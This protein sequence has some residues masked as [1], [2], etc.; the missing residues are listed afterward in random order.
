MYTLNG[1]W[2]SGRQALSSSNCLTELKTKPCLPALVS[3]NFYS[4][5]LLWKKKTG[6]A[7]VFFNFLDR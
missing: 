4:S 3:E 7:M 1:Y 5:F 2:W 6:V